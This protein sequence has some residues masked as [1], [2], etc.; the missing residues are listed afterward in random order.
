MVLLS[1]PI[2]CPPRENPYMLTEKA[3]PHPRRLYWSVL[4]PTL[5][6]ACVV[7]ALAAISVKVLGSIRGYGTGESA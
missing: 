4:A 2:R 3:R 7:A 5:V 6:M 1:P